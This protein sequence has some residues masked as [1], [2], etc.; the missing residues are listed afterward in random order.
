M[1]ASTKPLHGDS[2]GTS[3]CPRLQDGLGGDGCVP[4]ATILGTALPS[5]GL[6]IAVWTGLRERARSAAHGQ[7]RATEDTTRGQ[8]HG[9]ALL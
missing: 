2:L 9:A 5:A 8:S 3:F 7:P 6:A 1:A 4:P